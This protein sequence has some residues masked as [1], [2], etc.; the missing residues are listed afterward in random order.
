MTVVRFR[1]AAGAAMLVTVVLVSGCGGGTPNVQ[2]GTAAADKI[3]DAVASTF[4]QLDNAVDGEELS[5]GGIG[6]FAA[7]TGPNAVTYGI[8]SSLEAAHSTQDLTRFTSTLLS[9]FSSAGWRLSAT[10]TADYAA[11][12]NSIT[13]RLHVFQV[14]NDPASSLTVQGGCVDAGSAAKQI[15]TNHSGGLGD[16][17][18]QNSASVRPVPATFPT[19]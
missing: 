11:K 2:Q 17:Y 3:R 19:P 12:Q 13:V 1:S 6:R 7:C 18:E 9:G 8:L 5:T 4:W 15:V 16:Q 10:G 14:S